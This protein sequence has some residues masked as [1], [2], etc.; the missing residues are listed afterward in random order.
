MFRFVFGALIGGFAVWYWGEEMR[1]Y[2]ESRTVGV[3]RSAANMIRSVGKK[4]EDVLDRTKEH[5]SAVSQSGQDA[6]RP[7]QHH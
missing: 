1:E 6:I 2:A 4:A 3:R 7:P 5:V